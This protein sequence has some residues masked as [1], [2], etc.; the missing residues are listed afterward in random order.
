MFSYIC[1][2]VCVCVRVFTSS[3]MGVHTRSSPTFPCV[4]SSVRV[5]SVLARTR[6]DPE[7]ACGTASPRSLRQWHPGGVCEC[8]PL[9][10]GAA[11][12]GAGLAALREGVVACAHNGMNQAALRLR[13]G[14]GYRGGRGW[15]RE[16][17][18]ESS[19]GRGRDRGGGVEGAIVN[20]WRHRLDQS[21]I[22]CLLR[23]AL[24]GVSL[25]SPLLS[26]LSYLHLPLPLHFPSS[27]LL[28]PL[29]FPPSPLPY[30]TLGTLPAN[31]FPISLRLV[32]NVC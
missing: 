10:Q 9:C 16:G 29:F 31:V 32:N 3:V 14:T 26:F 24:L 13:G 15:G 20:V 25:S 11:R 22:H 27:T 5:P 8:V 23:F 19:W 6:T 21:L 12:E 18:R 17:G 30:P 2:R 7:S 28:L 4:R 1:I